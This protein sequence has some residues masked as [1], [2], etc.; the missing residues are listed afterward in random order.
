[1]TT[2]CYNRV[3][4]WVLSGSYRRAASDSHRL[5]AGRPH[6]YQSGPVRV[7]D[8]EDDG[9]FWSGLRDLWSLRD[10]RETLSALRV[11]YRQVMPGIDTPVT[12][13]GVMRSAF[14][15]HKEGVGSEQVFSVLKDQSDL[16]SLNVHVLGAP[17]SGTRH[18][19]RTR[20]HSSATRRDVCLVVGCGLIPSADEHSDPGH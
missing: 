10:L 19:R 11:K 9:G 1:M 18:T 2:S 8:Q 4:H 17:R 14:A 16:A 5:L 12:C 20:R 15:H 7:Y 13:I 3:L 6:Q